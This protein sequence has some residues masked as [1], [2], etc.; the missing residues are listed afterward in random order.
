MAML[1]TFIIMLGVSKLQSV[2]LQ[3]W[4]QSQEGGF[5]VITT[6]TAI[7]DRSISVIVAIMIAIIT[8]MNH[9]T[10]FNDCSDHIGIRLYL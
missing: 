6:I 4:L 9:G 3:Q 5:N 7:I 1:N 2:V 8:T 10:F